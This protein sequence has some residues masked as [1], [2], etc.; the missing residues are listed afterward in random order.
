MLPTTPLRGERR[1]RRHG[2]GEWRHG[3]VPLGGGEFDDE[4]VVGHD[5]GVDG[6]ERG[7]HVV[8][9]VGPRRWADVAAQ[10]RLTPLAGPRPR[11][12][13]VDDD[14]GA[15]RDD[16]RRPLSHGE[17]RGEPP[18]RLVFAHMSRRVC[19]A[20]ARKS[21]PS[22]CHR[23]TGNDDGDGRGHGGCHHALLSCSLSVVQRVWI[24]TPSLLPSS[25]GHGRFSSGPPIGCGAELSCLMRAA[26][27]G[28]SGRL[29]R[30]SDSAQRSASS[31]SDH[32]MRGQVSGARRW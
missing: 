31:K 5:D 25:T 28:S 14:L 9:A 32:A 30:A 19:D 27:G 18:V 26:R 4:A 2:D 15:D 11:R 29:Q 13:Q 17:L 10:R 7:L 8:V 23:C 12:H 16:D 24:A 3:R 21:R 6:V 20:A 22:F 1:Q